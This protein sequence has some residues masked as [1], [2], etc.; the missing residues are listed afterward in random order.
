MPLRER[1]FALIQV[2]LVFALLAVIVARLQYQQVVQRERA[3]LGLSL[4]QVQTC[5][6]STETLAQTALRLEAQLSD[7]Q[8]LSAMMDDKGN[9]TLG[10]PLNNC[11]LTVVLS[12]LQGRFNLNWLHPS[13]ANP[14]AAAAGFKRLL[15]QL[16]LDEGIADELL[17]WFDSDRGGEFNYIDQQPSYRPSF[18]PMA[19]VGELY[20]LKAITPEAFDALAPYVSTLRPDEPLNI[21]TATA[22][23][24]MTLAPFISREEADALTE[25]RR[26]HDF[27]RVDEL[28]NQSLFQENDDKPLYNEQLSVTSD[29][30]DLYVRAIYQ[31]LDVRQVSRLYRSE[32]NAVIVNFRTQAVNDPSI[33]MNDKEEGS[34]E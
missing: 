6:D 26:D 14:E 21:N 11:E 34:T 13:A 27:E 22:E 5:L 16:E 24:L 10:F 18:L 30:Y 32:N 3:S 7:A 31:E 9:A 33:L 2:L 25:Q 17:T 12:D 29:W 8:P 28:L 20:L 15:L 1:G 4:S 23:V 19:D